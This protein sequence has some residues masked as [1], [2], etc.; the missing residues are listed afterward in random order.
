MCLL[1]LDFTLRS[2]NYKL[3]LGQL[4]AAFKQFYSK[5]K[6]LK[7]LELIDLVLERYEAN[8]LFDVIARGNVHNVKMLLAINVT[9]VHCPL[10][11]IGMFHCLQVNA[12]IY[13]HIYRVILHIF[14]IDWQVLIISPQNIDDRLLQML[15]ESSLKHLYLL[16]NTHSSVSTSICACTSRAWTQFR[17]K[18]DIMR[19][20]LRLESLDD[21][22]ILLQPQAPVYSITYRNPKSKV[23]PLTERLEFFILF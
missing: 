5:C 9:I 17:K 14:H 1:W 21:G 2:F 13:F 6:A 4:I 22:S 10:I 15:A 20:H 23:M 11:Q 16:Q 8:K 12:L 3:V 18:N 7:R 19:I